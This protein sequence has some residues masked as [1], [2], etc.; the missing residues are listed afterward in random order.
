[1][2][3]DQNPRRG[4][5]HEL[6]F[7]KLSIELSNPTLEALRAIA[8][9]EPTSVTRLV[10][11]AVRDWLDHRRTSEVATQLHMKATLADL[12]ER[13]EDHQKGSFALNKSDKPIR[14]KEGSEQ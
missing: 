10:Q 3:A 1:M 2:T 4:R 13:G 14:K 5:R 7:T 11:R 9:S 6:G 12:F 8:K